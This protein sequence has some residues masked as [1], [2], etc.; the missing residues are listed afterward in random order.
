LNIDKATRFIRFLNPPFIYVGT[1][2]P[3][4]IQ[5]RNLLDWTDG[6]IDYI[7]VNLFLGKIGYNFGEELDL[8][9]IFIEKYWLRISEFEGNANDL[10][11]EFPSKDFDYLHDWNI[12]TMGK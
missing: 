1:I 12:E 10:L 8:P 3:G 4:N 5:Y 9:K 2:S 6:K 7:A 11:A